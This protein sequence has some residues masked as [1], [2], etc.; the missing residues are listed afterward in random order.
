MVGFTRLHGPRDVIALFTRRFG[1]FATVMLLTAAGM[2]LFIATRVPQFESSAQ[3]EIDVHRQSPA[4]PVPDKSD[5]GIVGTQMKRLASRTVA[6]RVVDQLGLAQDPEWAP[7][8]GRMSQA[9]APAAVRLEDSRRRRAIDT[10]MARLVVER[11]EVAPVVT[12]R[13]ASR[14]P[15][16]AAEIVNAVA[17][18]YLQEAADEA[19]GA[20]AGQARILDRQLDQQAADVSAA[21]AALADYRTAHGLTALSAANGGVAEQQA[22][23]L[24]GQLAAA[25]SEAAADQASAAVAAGM[26]ASGRSGGFSAALTSPV[27]TQLRQ[28]RETVAANVAQ[29]QVHYGPDHPRV[30]RLEAEMATVDAA[31]RSEE[32]RVAASVRGTAQAASQRVDEV[33]ARLAAVRSQQAADTTAQV[34]ADRLQR[35]A[36]AKRAT[37]VQLA[38][39]TAQSAQQGTLAI[40]PGA[41]IAGAVPAMVATYPKIMLLVMLALLASPTA[42]VVAVLLVEAF[43]TRV[44]G[45]GELVAI[46]GAGHVA[47]ISKVSGR[48]LRRIDGR[49]RPWDYVLAKPMS[50][51]AESVRA[52]RRYLA[53]H[54][55]GPRGMVVC[56]TSSV[57]HEGKSTLSASLARTMALAGDRVLLVDCDLR[58]NGL[59]D[60]LPDAP[61]A[62]LGEVLEGGSR[63]E[64]VLQRDAA[65]GLDL[66]PLAGPRFTP[67]DM[68]GDGRMATLLDRLRGEYE[69]VILDAPPA[70]IVDDAITLAGLSDAVLLTIR[71]GSTRIEAIAA[72]MQ[73]LRVAGDRA[74]G[75][76]M[77]AV[78]A[79]P[80]LSSS[81]D[82][83]YYLTASSG[84]HLN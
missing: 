18:S 80:A 79:R 52:V 76:V 70:L 33:A 27:L 73:R 64:E 69:Y 84:Y 49:A 14:N 50:S 43:D 48:A 77:T 42:G 56:V 16:R 65:P 21:D 45:A 68:F 28:Q 81:R 66:L 67:Q 62:G 75:L 2:A 41:V 25:Q 26:I 30:R 35:I 13:I 74:V 37:Y 20:A 72:A 9:F 38:Q 51:F 60:L 34:G 19:H 4:A 54:R 83:H 5:E 46:R 55:D 7:Q 58:R 15:V 40:R 24:A 57:S 36:D 3:I 29:A 32:G 47:A 6:G 11:D 31:I 10:L 22:T 1:L 23:A 71:W 44:R 17:E 53:F 59:A 61:D 78:D 63:Y 8:P 12:V 39:S 82:P